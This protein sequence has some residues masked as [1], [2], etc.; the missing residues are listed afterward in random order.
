MQPG[1]RLL[2]LFETDFNPAWLEQAIQLVD[3]MDD[4]F[5]DR[6]SGLYFHVARDQEDPPGA[7]QEHL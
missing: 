4:L 5:L 1:L 2:E 6:D 7:V 3:R